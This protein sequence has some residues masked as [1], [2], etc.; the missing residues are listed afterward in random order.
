MAEKVPSSDLKRVI[1]QPQPAVSSP[2]WLQIDAC[3]RQE[4]RAAAATRRFR[5]DAKRSEHVL[6]GRLREEEVG[7][8]CVPKIRI[9]DREHRPVHRV[10]A[11]PLRVV[12]SKRIDLLFEC[13]PDVCPEPVLAKWWFLAKTMAQKDASSD[14][15][16]V[17]VVQVRRGDR[18]AHHLS[19][20]VERVAK[21]HHTYLR[22]NGGLFWSFPYVCPEPVLVKSAFLYKF[23]K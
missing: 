14:D 1:V 20:D 11:G 16:R 13:F 10:A 4:V 8:G 22:Q 6:R 3:P 15:L 17:V 2:D 9:A 19:R 5:P 7:G 18:I 23:I 21:H 12:R